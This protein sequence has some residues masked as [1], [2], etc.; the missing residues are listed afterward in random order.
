M[1]IT[2]ASIGEAAETLRAGGAAVF[3]TDTVY[4]LGVAVDYAEGP[5]AVFA[6]KRRP[7]GKPVSWLVGGADALDRYARDVP[8]YAYDL[9]RE[10]WPGGLTLV[11]RASQEVPR[12]FC[13]ADGTIGLRMPAND[14]ALSL[15]RAVG[16]PLATSSAN[17]SGEPAVD[18]FEQLNPALPAAVPAVRD[19]SPKEGIASTVVDCTGIEPHVLRQGGVVLNPS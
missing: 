16:C 14:T 17:L 8:A 13:A 11:V 10:F 19:D 9:A 4:G 2:P 7:A 18:T 5:D 3:P 6:L 15:I 1:A 12:A